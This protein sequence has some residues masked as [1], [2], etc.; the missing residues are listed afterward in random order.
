MLDVTITYDR[1]QASAATLLSDSGTHIAVVNNAVPHALAA[2]ATHAGLQEQQHHATAT[3][4]VSM[5]TT[6]AARGLPA[7]SLVRV[8]QPAHVD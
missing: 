2:P 3:A 4:G 5:A 8:A 1:H 6:T 7:A